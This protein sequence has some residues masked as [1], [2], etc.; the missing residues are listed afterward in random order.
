MKKIISLLLLLLFTASFSFAQKKKSTPVVKKPLTPD[1]Y[2]GWRDINYKAL[3]PDGNYAALLINPQDGDGRAVFYNLSSFKE[4][5]VQRAAELTLTFDSKQAVFKIKPQKEKVKELRRQKKKKEDLPKD[6]LGIFNFSSRAVEKIAD[7]KSFKVPE[8]AGNW[9]AYTLEAKKEEKKTADKTDTTK[10][11]ESVKPVKK[12]KKNGDDNGYTLV[13]RRLSDKQEVTFS[14]VK[15]YA[16]A[17]FGQGIVFTSTG[18]DTTQKAGVYWYDLQKSSLQQIHEG[19]KKFKYKGLSINEDGNQ[20]AFLLDSDTTK[21]LLRQ[22]SLYHWQTSQDKAKELIS[23]QTSGVPSEW[24]VSEHYTPL[25]SQNSKTLFVGLAPRPLLPDTTKLDEEIIKVDI[26]NWRDSVLQTQ[27]ARQL[28]NEKKRSYLAAYNLQNNTLKAL[29]NEH[30]PSITLTD[31]GNALYA[32]AISD[33]PYRWSN[34]YDINTPQDAYVINIQ[35]GEQKQIGKALKGDTFISPKGNYIYWYSQIDTAWF[36]FSINSSQ[37]HSLTKSLPVA[38]ADEEDD[39]PD[40]PSAY[41]RLGWT[42]GDQQFLVY[43]RYDIWSLDP[44]NKRAAINL[45]KVGRSQ[46]IVFR[47]IKLDPEEKFIK[48]DA[49]LLLSAFNEVTKASGYYS[50]NLKTNELKKLLSSDNRYAGT[51]KAMQSDKILFT[52]ESFTEFPDV[53]VSN[54]SFQSPKKLTNANPQMKNYKWG[55][56]ELVKF[57]SL[58]NVPLE[59]LLYKPEN[60]DP[61]K[62]YPMLVYFYEKSSEQLYSHFKPQPAWSIIQRVMCVSNDYLVFIPD[63]VYKI[64]LPGE[65][66]YNSIMP[67]VTSMIAK[68]F[69]DEKNIGIQGQ[70]WGGYQTAYIITRTNLFKAAGAG[71]AVVNMT[72]A[73]GGIRWGSGLSRMF[74][75]EQSQSRI[76]GTLWDKPLYYLENSPLFTADKIQT[77]VLIMQNDKDDAVPWYQGIEFYMALRRLQKPVWMLVYNDEVHNLQQRQ[78]R[79]DYDIRLMQF[80][81]YYLK[82]AE[83]PLWMKQGIKAT[84]KGILKGF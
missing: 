64:G 69:V 83:E 43:D 67:G 11:K 35:S 44:E 21:A 39:H 25:F 45:T 57:T 76:G 72:S 52:R 24:L 14:Y 59:G 34:F 66:A 75:Y 27:Q 84:E 41:G 70:S 1:V 33:K 38:F 17:K 42:E 12:A 30:L 51:V 53:W 68:G 32:L 61:T 37:I 81:D 3:T 71:A 28:E 15:D 65:S 7:V 77:P 73:Y 78:N 55:S 50:L 74:Q 63:I 6:S 13:L 5:S 49:Q 8:K 47:Y 56:V 10:K 22:F 48:A 29:S 20:L 23:T 60:F 40:Y 62:K 31:E 58:D 54:L 16:F 26:W 9:L 19:H 2:D 82:G 79:K 18:N 46:K 80:F 4:G 36:S